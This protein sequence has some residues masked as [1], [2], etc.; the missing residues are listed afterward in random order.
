M[1]A[2]LL[3]CPVNSFQRRFVPFF[4][5]NL[6][7][8]WAGVAGL[9]EHCDQFREIDMARAKRREIPHARAAQLVLKMTMRDQRQRLWQID[10]YRDAAEVLA[11]GGVVV[12]PDRRMIDLLD[13]TACQSAGAGQRAVDF[14]TDD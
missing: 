1:L 2:R 3:H 8:V 9:L 10:L 7:A 4:K 12:D 6:D 13:Q 5:L 14:D 11:V